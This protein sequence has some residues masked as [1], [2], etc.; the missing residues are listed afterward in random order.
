MPSNLRS[1]PRRRRT[2][3]KRDQSANVS[4]GVGAS[5]RCIVVATNATVDV[6]F[7]KPV[8]RSVIQE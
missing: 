2:Q 7:E 6:E 8:P 4:A 1:A 5:P 3:L